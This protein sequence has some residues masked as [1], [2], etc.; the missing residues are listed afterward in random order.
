MLLSVEAYALIPQILSVTSTGNIL[1]RIPESI[2]NTPIHFFRVRSGETPTIVTPNS[3]LTNTG[4]LFATG[5]FFKNIENIDLINGA[6]PVKVDSHGVF[7]LPSG[8]KIDILPATV[9]N[10]MQL[11][12]MNASGSVSHTHTLAFPDGTLFFDGSKATK[13]QTGVIINSV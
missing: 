8:Y 5:S 3:S 1:G 10:P 2:E 9:K 11:L 12:T 6:N 13:S 4:G 7:I